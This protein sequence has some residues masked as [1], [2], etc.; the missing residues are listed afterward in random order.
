MT[1]SGWQT[2]IHYEKSLLVTY[3][4]RQGV[5]RL[6]LETV[7]DKPLESLIVVIQQSA[8]YRTSIADSKN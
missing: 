5:K 1:A 7:V 3:S 6:T 8:Y 2:Q 4:A